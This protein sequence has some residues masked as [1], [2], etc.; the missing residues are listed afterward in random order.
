MNV[1]SL[2]KQQAIIKMN[3]N[4]LSVRIIAKAVG[5]APGTVKKYLKANGKS[6]RSVS[7][8]MIKYHQD[9]NTPWY[10]RTYPQVNKKASDSQCRRRERESKIC[11]KPRSHCV[12]CKDIFSSEK[13]TWGKTR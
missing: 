2:D 12:N 4:G 10:T 5:C 3:T 9:K 7:E 11:M 1:L 6:P 8:A 13:C